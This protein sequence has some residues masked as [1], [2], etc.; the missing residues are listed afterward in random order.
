M[1]D[2]AKTLEMDPV[3]FRLM[4]HLEIGERIPTSPLVLQSCAVP[5]CAE[6]AERMRQAI[7]ERGGEPS[8]P[9]PGVVEAWGVAFCCHTSGPSNAEGM[10]SGLIL[11]NDD[12][13]VNLM[14]GSADIGQGSETTLSQIVAEE[15]GVRL[16]DVRVTGGGHA[17]HA[18]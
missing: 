5:E 15:L 17:A 14:T 12:G 6:E 1:D 16:E 11:L 2:I 18:L 7:E 13:S 3:R 8:E 9:H 4:N 10:S